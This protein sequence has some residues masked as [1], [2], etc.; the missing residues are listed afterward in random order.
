MPGG[1]DDHHVRVHV[2]D[3][4]LDDRPHAAVGQGEA[5]RARELL[6]GETVD[7]E[8]PRAGEVL[9]DGTR[10]QDDLVAARTRVGMVF[11][12]PRDG[13]VAASVGADVAFGPENL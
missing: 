11:Q 3:V 12:N 2:D 10:V 1:L 7:L 4:G 13:F 5:A 6:L 8:G 9:V